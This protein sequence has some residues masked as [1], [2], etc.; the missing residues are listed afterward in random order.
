[1]NRY[2]EAMKIME[3][4]FGHDML[5]SVATIDGNRPAVR[6]VNSYYENGAF[7]TVTYALSNKM[8]QIAVNPNVGV[9]GEWFAAH[10]IGE[11]IGWIRA[12]QNAK[13]PR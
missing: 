9:C 8:K 7:Y 12:E 5:I 6:T 2:E 4:R 13:L 1:M 3:E 10:G 11:N